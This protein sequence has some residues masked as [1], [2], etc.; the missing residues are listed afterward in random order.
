VCD[1]VIAAQP[2]RTRSW[3]R[4]VEAPDECHIIVSAATRTLN[5]NPPVTELM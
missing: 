1:D 5:I 3:A 2:T 4:P